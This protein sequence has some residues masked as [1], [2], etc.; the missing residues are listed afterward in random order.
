MTANGSAQPEVHNLETL[1]QLFSVPVALKLITMT[2][3]MCTESLHE[4]VD[5]TKMLLKELKQES[6]QSKVYHLAPEHLWFGRGDKE[7]PAF[8]VVHV[9]VLWL[10]L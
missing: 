10:S 8:I 1:S 5:R 7:E 9:T 2:E 3:E 6:Y 4:R